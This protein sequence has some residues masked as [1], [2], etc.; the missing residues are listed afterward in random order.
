[1]TLCSAP[2]VSIDDTHELAAAAG[3]IVLSGRRGMIRGR[4]LRNLKGYRG[5]LWFDPALYTRAAQ[6]GPDFGDLTD[7]AG[8]IPSP[9]RESGGAAYPHG[10]SHAAH[11]SV[12]EKLGVTELLTAAT[13]PLRA[14]DLT[15]LQ[16]LLNDPVWPNDARVV[17]PLDSSWL[18]YSADQLVEEIWRANRPVAITFPAIVDPTG[19][20][21]LRGGHTLDPFGRPAKIQGLLTLAESGLDILLLNVEPAAIGAVVHGVGAA[22]LRMGEG[23]YLPALGAFHGFTTL[24]TMQAAGRT[25]LDGLDYCPC[26]HCD[27]RSLIRFS[28]TIDPEPL[29]ERAELRGEQRD[30][31]AHNAASLLDLLDGFRKAA[32]SGRRQEWTEHCHRS[33]LHHEWLRDARGIDL[34]VPR[35][36]QAWIA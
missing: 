4:Q 30:L 14:G 5:R 11:V 8:L 17:L 31:R 22:A 20:P 29:R 26:S 23:V 24:Q 12:Q 33:V 19:H 16:G 32:R 25:R 6:Y 7:A 35:S 9:R 15:G 10:L 2:D 3:G 21:A 18:A 34:T 36:L 1:M 28:D 27:G 13:R